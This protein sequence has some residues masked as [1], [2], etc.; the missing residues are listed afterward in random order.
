MSRHIAGNDGDAGAGEFGIGGG[1]DII[2]GAGA[3]GL[4]G[5]AFF[6]QRAV[7]ALDADAQGG[8]TALILGD[9]AQRAAGRAVVGFGFEAH[10][11]GHGEEVGHGHV[12]CRGAIGGQGGIP[13]QLGGIAQ[14]LAGIVDRVEEFLLTQLDLRGVGHRHPARRTGH[15]RASFPLAE[16]HFVVVL[17]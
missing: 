7:G 14:R 11:A 8:D 12:V 6:Q 13:C 4:H 17:P 3:C 5:V 10:D 9:H 1:G 15:D 2:P 16:Y